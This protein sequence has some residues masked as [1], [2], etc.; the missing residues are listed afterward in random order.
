M[1]DFLSQDLA[2]RFKHHAPAPGVVPL[3]EGVRE[4]CLELA[5]QLNELV[6]GGREIAISLQKL[7]EVMFWANAGIARRCARK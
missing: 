2:W 6:P 4:H 3:H 5:N 7:E 1:T